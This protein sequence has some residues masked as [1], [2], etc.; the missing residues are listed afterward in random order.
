[1]SY[2]KVVYKIDS[3]DTP[4]SR[5]YHADSTDIAADMF[6]ATCEQSLI[7]EVVDVVKIVQV[8]ERE[9]LIHE[10]GCGDPECT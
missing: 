5:F 7:G 6:N 8:E 3:Y 2:Y 4:H 1:M 9:E 10:C